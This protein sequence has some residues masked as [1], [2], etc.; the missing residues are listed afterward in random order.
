TC[1]EYFRGKDLVS[2]LR[3]HPEVKEILGSDKHLETD[4]IGNIL[5]KK[6]LIVRCDLSKFSGQGRR[7]FPHGQHTWR[8]ILGFPFF[9]VEE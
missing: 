2:F 5:L 3:S 4:G 1:V 8:Y 9:A 7:S 6:N